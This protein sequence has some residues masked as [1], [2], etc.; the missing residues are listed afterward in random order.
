M[1]EQYLFPYP[2]GRYLEALH[3]IQNGLID[4]IPQI[5]LLSEQ[6]E[7]KLAAAAMVKGW[8]IVV[9]YGATHGTAFS[10]TS[11]DNIAQAR[12]EI[13]TTEGKWETVSLVSTH[14][15]VMKN[16]LD[17]N[18]L[19]PNLIQAASKGSFKLFENIAFVQLPVS[20]RAVSDLG[21]NYINKNGCAQFFF[22]SPDDLFMSE[23]QRQS[24]FPC[25]A[26][27]S[28]NIHGSSEA[29]TYS[30]GMD[31]APQIG[32]PYYVVPTPNSLKALLGEDRRLRQG[33]QPMYTFPL[34][35]DAFQVTIA[36]IGNTGKST[37]KRLIQG[38]FGSSLSVVI[39][40]LK[41]TPSGRRPYDSPPYL[42]D[43]V[44]I[45]NDLLRAS[46]ML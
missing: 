32:A 5:I 31:F 2:N 19:H 39:Q 36:R 46:G 40:L 28:A 20:N 42:M 22:T 4:Y 18:R 3:L 12:R 41:P 37:S 27:R 10:L 6:N 45:R 25:Y 8:P 35:G 23:L 38:I 44:S 7:T 34:Q 11:R 15:F 14:D 24:R 9:F 43:P 21:Q 29:K 16:W 30:E 33:S 17:W 26:V 1:V 13:R